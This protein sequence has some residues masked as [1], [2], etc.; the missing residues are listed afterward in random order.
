MVN[1]YTV[2]YHSNP[3]QLISRIHTLYFYGLQRGWSLSF[4]NFFQSLY[5]LPW[6][7]KSFKFI[8]LRLLQIHLW[9]KKL[10]LFIF[11]H[12]PKQNSPSGF[13]HYPTGKRELSIPFEQCFLKI[14][15]LR[16]GSFDTF[17]HLCKRYIFVLCFVV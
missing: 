8:V 6:L 10:S 7:Q 4:L 9:V 14:F 17:R 13:Y 2:D 16:R 5:I 11:T 12:A 15:F 3:S 1:K